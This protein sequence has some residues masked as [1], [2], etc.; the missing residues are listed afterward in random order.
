MN[1]ENIY[2]INE[3]LCI[4]LGIS[5]CLTLPF[6]LMIYHSAQFQTNSYDGVRIF[7]RFCLFFQRLS[8]HFS[9]VAKDQPFILGHCKIFSSV[10]SRETYSVLDGLCFLFDNNVF[11]ECFTLCSVLRE[12]HKCLFGNTFL[13]KVA[14]EKPVDAI[15]G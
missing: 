8:M 4:Y 15:K 3:V 13:S 12:A 9:C 2:S 11:W 1:R 6:S 14:Y 5:S 7:C 10:F